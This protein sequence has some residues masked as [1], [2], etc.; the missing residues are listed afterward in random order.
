MVHFL[1]SLLNL[2]LYCFCFMLWF[3]GHEAPKMEPVPPVL[4]GKSVNLWT[5]RKVPTRSSCEAT[6]YKALSVVPVT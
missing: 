1:K 3:F 5:T 4:E 6:L 2:L